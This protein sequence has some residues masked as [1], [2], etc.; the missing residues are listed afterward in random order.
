VTVDGLTDSLRFARRLRRELDVQVIPGA[1]FGVEG[2]LRL[3]FGLSPAALQQALDVLTLG[4]GAL[5]E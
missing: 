4:L 1:F 2:T 5:V 3:S